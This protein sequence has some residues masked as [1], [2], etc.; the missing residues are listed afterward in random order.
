MRSTAVPFQSVIPRRFELTDQPAAHRAG[1]EAQQFFAVGPILGVGKGLD[2][3]CQSGVTGVAAEFLSQAAE[4]LA[5]LA[6]LVVGCPALMLAAR[7]DVH[8]VAGFSEDLLLTL[9]VGARR[10]PA[11]WTCPICT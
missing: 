11:A 6:A 5:G 4:L 10:K 8:G 9:G 1:L 2:P 7:V 3:S